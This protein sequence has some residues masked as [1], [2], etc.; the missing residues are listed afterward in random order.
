M[1][2]AYYVQCLDLVRDVCEEGCVLV[3]EVRRF[4]DAGR[5]SY[6]GCEEDSIAV[7]RLV[8]SVSVLFPEQV[9]QFCLRASGW[10]DGL[11][12][13]L[14]EPHPSPVG[15]VW[16]IVHSYP[17]RL[18]ERAAD[19]VDRP[20]GFIIQDTDGEHGFVPPELASPEA[21]PGPRDVSRR[22]A[23]PY[24][25][26]ERGTS[27]LPEPSE[28]VR[29][30]SPDPHAGWTDCSARNSVDRDFWLRRE[31]SRQLGSDSPMSPI[32]ECETP[33]PVVYEWSPRSPSY[34]AD[35]P[36]YSPR[37]PDVAEMSPDVTGLRVDSAGRL[38]APLTPCRAAVGAAFAHTS[39]HLVFAYEDTA[40]LYTGL[41]AP[42]YRVGQTLP[43]AGDSITASGNVEPVHQA[44][45]FDDASVPMEPRKSALARIGRSQSLPL[46]R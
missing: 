9:E 10:Q 4:L 32:A 40:P 23:T 39:T 46:G 14:I 16:S 12:V 7:R 2:F 42:G 8:A 13:S 18:F 6:I 38:P 41:N 19:F 29:E 11:P 24:P 27:E 37:L 3:E 22:R 28:S 15:T 26:R 31:L 34:S 36:V 21:S 5:Y 1:S 30:E 20:H 45:D 33:V 25:S 35:S 17:A 44:V 43:R